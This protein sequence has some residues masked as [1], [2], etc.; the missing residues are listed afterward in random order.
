MFSLR[1]TEEKR[2]TLARRC[3][4]DL[5]ATKPFSVWM[6][7]S[8][9]AK[10]SSLSLFPNSVFRI[11]STEQAKS[12]PR[13]PSGLL[14]SRLLPPHLPACISRWGLGVKRNTS[15]TPTCL[16]PRQVRRLSA[17]PRGRHKSGRP[18]QSKARI[19]SCLVFVWSGFGEGGAEDCGGMCALVPEYFSLIIHQG[20]VSSKL[21]LFSID[22]LSWHSY[23]Y[24]IFYHF[25]AVLPL[26]LLHIIWLTVKVLQSGVE[27]FLL[28]LVYIACKLFLLLLLDWRPWLWLVRGGRE[29]WRWRLRLPLTLNCISFLFSPPPEGPGLRKP[30]RLTSATHAQS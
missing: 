12:P 11:Y 9:E 20:N 22:A 2:Q 3:G 5:Q 27:V 30:K 13:K 7:L 14:P 19:I 15:V 28:Y 29:W 6:R 18:Q 26:I 24:T 4:Q 1:F 17:D 10:M 25:D 21:L 8:S 23:S 16:P